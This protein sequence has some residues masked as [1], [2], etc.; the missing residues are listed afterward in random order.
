MARRNNT[1]AEE[2]TKNMSLARKARNVKSKNLQCIQW[3]DGERLK[4]FI[5][6]KA[7]ASEY[8]QEM[9]I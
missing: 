5:N 9:L 3:T 6:R 1:E 4:A 2:L 7:E 8:F